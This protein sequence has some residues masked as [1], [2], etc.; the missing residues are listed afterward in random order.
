MSLNKREATK[1]TSF[2]DIK[3]DSGIVEALDSALRPAYY[4]AMDVMVS[5]GFDVRDL[6]ATNITKQYKELKEAA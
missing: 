2:K 4:K 5:R 1:M 6:L 3:V